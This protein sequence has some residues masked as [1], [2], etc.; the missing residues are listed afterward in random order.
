MWW[1]TEHFDC[2]QSLSAAMEMVLTRG[3][4]SAATER[5]LTRGWLSAANGE[6]VN[7]RLVISC[8]GEGANSRLVIEWMIKL[9]DDNP[10]EL[11][12]LMI[13]LTL[14]ALFEVSRC[15]TF[16][17]FRRILQAQVRMR[18]YLPYTVFGFKRAVNRGLLYRVVLI[19]VFIPSAYEIYEFTICKKMFFFSNLSLCR[20]FKE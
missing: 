6:G 5:V 7:S 14:V 4:L 12:A 20:R 19:P 3:W 9:S 18:Y 10:F 8:Y 15:I 11:K 17:L 13:R 2:H 16:Q 1:N